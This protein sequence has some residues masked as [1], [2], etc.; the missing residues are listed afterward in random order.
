M[1][2]WLSVEFTSVVFLKIK[3]F[4]II[5]EN[6]WREY[7]R[8]HAWLTSMY[9]FLKHIHYDV[10]TFKYLCLSK[11]FKP[12]FNPKS[13]IFLL[14]FLYLIVEW[15]CFYHLVSEKGG[16]GSNLSIKIKTIL[17]VLIFKLGKVY[18]EDDH[19]SSKS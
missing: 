7:C 13:N 6:C 11:H 1:H 16:G 14:S 15:T 18:I 4:S 8:E 12:I 9:H 5:K 2:E 10:Y 17:G 3:A 19:D